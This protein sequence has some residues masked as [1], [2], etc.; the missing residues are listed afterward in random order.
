MS[1]L[2]QKLNKRP[3]RNTRE[4]AASRVLLPERAPTQDGITASPNT[5][6]PSATTSAGSLI[7]PPPTTASLTQELDRSGAGALPWWIQSPPVPNQWID[8][9]VPRALQSLDRAAIA[10]HP[11]AESLRKAARKAVLAAAESIS[12]EHTLTLAETEDATNAAL[13]LLCGRGPLEPLCA[14]PL[15][16]DI[17]VNAPNSVQ[18]VRRG[19]VL[20]TPFHFRSAAEYRSFI[21]T[22][23][24]RSGLALSAE[25]PVAIGSL[26]ETRGSRLSVIH[27]SLLA[28]AEP[29]LALRLPRLQQGT[30]YELI[31]TKVLPASLAAWLTEVMSLP[32]C[33]IVI[34]GRGG[35]GKTTLAAALLAATPSDARIFTVEEVAEIFPSAHYLEKFLIRPDRTVFAAASELVEL[36]LQRAPHWIAI[37]DLRAGAAA[38]LIRAFHGN[39]SC[40]MTVQAASEDAAIQTLADDLC[41]QPGF[42]RNDD[43]PRRLRAAI[44]LVISMNSSEGRPYIESIRERGSSVE[45]PSIELVRFAGEQTGKR[46]WHL[47]RPSS[48]LIQVVRERGHE[49]RLGA[50]LLA[51]P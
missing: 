43:T 37:G 34:T 3:R 51:A 44:D 38:A 7:S 19:Q 39:L 32:H 26:P 46:A 5:P 11:D 16:T 36:A 47:M 20:D 8:T 21:Q 42:A 15:V 41:T 17:F 45:E 29:S 4:N 30:M 6:S 10:T 50:G 22:L 28:G 33:S 49:L 14:D 13:Q 24:E 48:R 35:S 12:S 18:C 40:V 1:G 2:L 27:P 31:R 9:V 23:L 25:Q